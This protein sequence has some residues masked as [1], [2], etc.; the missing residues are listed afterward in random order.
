MATGLELTT[1]E[2]VD[3]L[4]GWLALTEPDSC[5]LYAA[6]E[7]IERGPVELPV[8]YDGPSGPSAAMGAG[9]VAGASAALLARPRTGDRS[10]V[11]PLAVRGYGADGSV[12]ATRLV[13]A[14][15]A[16]DDA[17]RPGSELMR[18]EVLPLPV[19][20]SGDGGSDDGGSDDGGAYEGKYVVDKRY[21]RVLVS[22]TATATPSQ[23][24]SSECG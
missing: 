10:D 13:A 4:F 17:G 22:W 19:G 23:C 8:V 3:G 14:A 18:V 15:R 11:A 21:V 24:R 9:L 16:W 7:A 2:L 5:G 6:A 20:G 12:L 1:P